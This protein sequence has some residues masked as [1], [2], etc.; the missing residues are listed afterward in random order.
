MALTL[1]DLRQYVTQVIGTPDTNLPPN[2]GSATTRGNLVVNQ[3]GRYLFKHLWNFRITGPVFA[4]F[5]APISIA[6]GTWTH[7]T[8]TLTKTAGFASYTFAKS[9][10]I[11][12]TGGTGATTGLYNIAS[13]T[14]DDAIVL[15]TSIGA[16]ADGQTNIGGT[17]EFPYVNLPSDFG[18]LLA[19]EMNSSTA[20]LNLTS[21]QEV[22]SRR[23]RNV[24]VN[25][26]N[27]FAA[28]THPGQTAVSVAF[29]VARLELDHAPQAVDPDALFVSYWRAWN[30][31]STDT[32]YAQLPEFAEDLL[33]AYIRAFSEGYMNAH[34]DED[35][36]LPIA[37]ITDRLTE[38]DSGPL[39]HLTKEY[40]GLLQ[41]DYG[42]AGEG[43]A[44]Y[45]SDPSSWRSRSSSPV[46]DP[47]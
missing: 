5:T 27:Y 47:A 35:G 44:G 19:Y 1:L 25:A 7:A 14:S 28:I 33:I 21:I 24:A 13:R 32:D 12:I 3:A 2:A 46:S 26:N 30:T 38:I 22:M 31:L 34:A 20:I 17:I 6:N 40:D 23:L 18:A 16:A 29:P 43:P 36:I 41:S 15:S 8:K 37:T 45:P 39:F 11:E 9:D 10:I 4:G 42:P